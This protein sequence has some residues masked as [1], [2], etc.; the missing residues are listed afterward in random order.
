M[1]APD[2]EIAGL[3]YRSDGRR[4]RGRSSSASPASG[5]TGTTSRPT[6]SSAAPRRS[7][8]SARSASACPRWSSTTCAR[9]WGPPRRASTATRPRELRGGRHH[10]HERQDHHRVPGARTCSRPAGAACGLLGTVKRVVGGPRGGGRAHDARGDRPAGDLPAR[11]ST[12]ATAPARWRSPRT[13]SSWARASGI[14]FACRG[15]H[16]PDPGP[17]RLPRDDGGLLR[18]Q[19]AAVR[20]RRGRAVVNVDD[21]YGR[22]LADEVRTASTFAVEREADYRARD[23][24]FDLTGSRF[25]C[26]TPDGE[27]ELRLAAAGA[28][29]RLERAR[30]GRGRAL[31]GRAARAR[32]RPRCRASGRVPGRFEPVDEGQDFG[33]LVDYAHTP[34]ALENVLRA[35]RELTERARCTCVFGA[36]GDRDRGKRPLMGDGG[37]PAGRPRARDLATTRAPRTPTRSSTR[38][39]RAPAPA[40]SAMTDRR[41]R[42]RAARSSRRGAGRRRRDRRQG[43][44]A[45][46]GV[47]GR[48]QGAVRRRDGRARGAAA[49]A[50]ARRGVID[51]SAERVAQAAGG[52]ARRRRRRARRT[53]ARGRRLARGRARATCSSACRARAPT[54]ASSPPRRSTPAPGACSSAASARGEARPPTASGTRRAAARP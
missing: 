11:C 51:L 17:P 52:A 25:R 42:D 24:G 49:R 40:P 14:H 2:V 44:R 26:Q 6:P 4:A 47:R 35:A 32:S 7:S 23:V 15:V 28:V 13:R 45:G 33:V 38:S 3:A 46:P 37:A 19:A 43:P 53:R 48:P 30:R 41:R 21:E 10:R 27:V 39:W 29:Q 12:P 36:G 50:T 34:E 9:R 31:A 5:P 54:A 8:A 18:R 22:R 1:D 16:Q 20:R